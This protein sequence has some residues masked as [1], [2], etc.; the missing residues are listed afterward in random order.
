MASLSLKDFYQDNGVR[1]LPESSAQECH[2]GLGPS[3]GHTLCVNNKEATRAG[4][5]PQ[6]ACDT[7][8]PLF[9]FCSCFLPLLM[10]P[11]S[12]ST[13]LQVLND[14]RYSVVLSIYAFLPVCSLPLLLLS[15]EKFQTIKNPEFRLWVPHTLCIKQC[16]KGIDNMKHEISRRCG[17]TDHSCYKG[18]QDS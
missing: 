6:P 10:R 17:D 15:H 16:I 2:G 13:L 11:F 3:W 8:C 5:T 18:G 7:Q 4:G 14:C 12:F 9:S 1:K